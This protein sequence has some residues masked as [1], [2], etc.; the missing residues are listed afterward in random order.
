NV[1]NPNHLAGWHTVNPPDPGAALPQ[2]WIN[3][4]QQA[5][6]QQGDYSLFYTW[7][8]SQSAITD[9][10]HIDGYELHG[11]YVAD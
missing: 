7:C 1:I 8:D 5:A 4:V 10:N 3:A 9:N 2:G 11:S 6:Q